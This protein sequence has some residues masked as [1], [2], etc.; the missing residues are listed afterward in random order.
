MCIVCR[1]DRIPAKPAPTSYRVA[2]ELLGADPGGSVA[3]EDS[4]YGV[5]AALAAGLFTVATP[6]RLTTGLDLS[7]ADVVI[8][9]LEELTLAEALAR[10]TVRPHGSRQMHSRCTPPRNQGSAGRRGAHDGGG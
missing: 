2:C 4:P 7:A 3:V 6:H 9:S 8:G 10:A 1:D 5:T